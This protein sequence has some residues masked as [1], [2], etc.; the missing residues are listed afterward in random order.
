MGILG[1]HANKS[2]VFWRYTDYQNGQSTR[3]YVVLGN[4]SKNVILLCEHLYH[5]EHRKDWNLLVSG[6]LTQSKTRAHDVVRYQPAPRLY[7][8]L[9]LPLFA[10]YVRLI[11]KILLN[12]NNKTVFQNI[13]RHIAYKDTTN[14]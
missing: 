11:I 7:D 9:I 5:M 12:F 2:S 14:V 10:D 3:P 8:I 1:V 6:T 13:K 4:R